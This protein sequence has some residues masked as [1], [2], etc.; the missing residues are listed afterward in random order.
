[1]RA[2]VLT[3]EAEYS[4]KIHGLI[5]VTCDAIPE[6]KLG[7][8][9][10]PPGLNGVGKIMMTWT[11]LGHSFVLEGMVWTVGHDAYIDLTVAC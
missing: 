7:E 6:V 10:G 1:M 3:T 8:T 11:P 9:S 4:G 5:M 2:K